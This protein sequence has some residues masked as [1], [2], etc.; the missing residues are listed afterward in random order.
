MAITAWL[1]YTLNAALHCQGNDQEDGGV[2]RLPVGPWVGRV[3]GEKHTNVG[4]EDACDFRLKLL[5]KNLNKVAG[6]TSARV[7]VYCGRNHG[8]GQAPVGE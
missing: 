3:L 8:Q 4:G 6:G 1:T 5:A 7:K 2:F